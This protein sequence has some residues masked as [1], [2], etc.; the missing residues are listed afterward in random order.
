MKPELDAALCAKYPKMFVN[1]NKPM[2][3]TCMC[4]G[5]SCG[6]GWYNIIDSLCE[7]MTYTYKTS[8]KVEKDRAI[9]MGIQKSE[10]ADADDDA[11]YLDVD[12]PQVIVDQVKEKYGTLRFYYH[13]EFEPNI[14]ELAYGENHDPE[15]RK[16]AERF[17]SYMDGIVHYAEC[18]SA[19]TCEETGLPG[20]MHV[21]GGSRYGWYRTLNRE[22]AKTDEF[23]TSRDYV[24]V[25]DLPK[26]E[27]AK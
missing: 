2:N 9:K 23:C 6:D 24:P 8:L 18:L 12:A 10:W 20:E 3:E 1:R 25:A 19:R 27:E 21:S 17:C 7:A 22:F 5:F 4:W 26:E 11:Y 16:V 14:R 13:L 15:A